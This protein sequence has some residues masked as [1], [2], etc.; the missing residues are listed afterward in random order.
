MDSTEIIIGLVFFLVISII[1]FMQRGK[2]LERMKSSW[3][4]SRLRLKDAEAE[5]TN[6]QL[7]RVNQ[8]TLKRAEQEISRHS[9]E[10]N[11]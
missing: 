11:K 3:D 10:K 6:S 1:S 4:Y 2:E 9:H 5:L 8:K 7:E